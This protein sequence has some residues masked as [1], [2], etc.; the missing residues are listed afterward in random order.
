[1]IRIA[2]LLFPIIIL[3]VACAQDHKQAESPGDMIRVNWSDE[4]WK[5]M[6]TPIQY[7]VTR[8]KGTERAFT[9]EYWNHKEKGVYHCVCCENPLFDSSAKFNSGTGWPSYYQ[10]IKEQNVKEEMDYSFGVRSEVLCAK[11]DAHLGHVFED[12]PEL[13]GLRYCINS[14]SLKFEAR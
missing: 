1:M 9:G 13:T 6:L 3:Q 5:Q 7:H 2:I 11:C 12:G 10:P 4:Q 8:E 14:A